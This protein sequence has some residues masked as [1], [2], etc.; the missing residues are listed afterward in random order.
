MRSSTPLKKAISAAVVLTIQLGPALYL[1][2]WNEEVSA[3]RGSSL[4]GTMFNLF[5]SIRMAPPLND[6]SIVPEV[7]GVLYALFDYGLT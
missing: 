2:E 1:E 4:T 5:V 3:G 7:P 6:T